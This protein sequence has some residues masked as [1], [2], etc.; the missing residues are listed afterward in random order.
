MLTQA[1]LESRSGTS[2]FARN[3]NNYFGMNANTSNPED[4]FTY[5][6]PEDSARDYIRRIREYYPNA[7]NETEFEKQ[8]EIVAPVYATDTKYKEKV[9]QVY[10]EVR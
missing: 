3:R 9:L 1:T 2:N 4:A 10:A 7:Y 8:I 5:E 6:T